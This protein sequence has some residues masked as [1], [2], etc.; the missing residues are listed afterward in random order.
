MS[1]KIKHEFHEYVRM[2]AKL[3]NTN[4]QTDS[5]QI[6]D[7]GS[8][9]FGNEWGGCFPED[10]KIKFNY[11]KSYYVFNNDKANQPGM[12]WIAVYVHHPTKTV[13][14]FD[15]FNRQ[16]SKILPDVDIDIKEH[17]FKVRKGEDDIVQTDEQENCGQRS[18]SWLCLVNKYGIDKVKNKL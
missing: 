17:H 8:E 7:A 3:F 15:T 18:L 9:L 16:T 10:T 13:Y 11:G 14:V 6:N 5:E 2:F 4:S 12:H 1:N